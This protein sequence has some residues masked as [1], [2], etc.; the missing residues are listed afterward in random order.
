M[1]ISEQNDLFEIAKTLY[2]LFFFVD[3]NIDNRPKKFN[4]SDSEI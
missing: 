4:D 2:F 3:L 1:N